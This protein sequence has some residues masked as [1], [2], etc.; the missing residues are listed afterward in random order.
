[1][2][3]G[4]YQG[5]ISGDAKGLNNGL[6]RGLTHGLNRNQNRI[7]AYQEHLQRNGDQDDPLDIDYVFLISIAESRGYALPSTNCQRSGSR[8]IKALKK[9]KIWY[10]VDVLY[11][12]ATD[13]D[14][15]FA[16]LNWKYPQSRQN[17]RVGTLTFT[18]NQG[19]AGNGTNSYLDLNFN[20]SSQSDW[21]AQNQNCWVVGINSN[22]AAASMA[23]F[24]AR[25]TAGTLSVS[26]FYSRIA[27]DLTSARVNSAIADAI[28][29]ANA[30]SI[31][32]YIGYRTA[33]ADMQLD[34]DG[35]FLGQDATATSRAFA[36]RN[37]YLGC[38]NV[39]GVASNFS[40]RQMTHWGFG[41]FTSYRTEW[42]LAWKE[43]FQSL[44]VAQTLPKSTVY[45]NLH[46]NRHVQPI[47][48]GSKDSTAKDYTQVSFGCMV[49]HG[50][51]WFVYYLGSSALIDS[52]RDRVFGAVKKKDN[53]VHLGWDKILDGSSKP[54]V[55]IDIGGIGAFDETQVF[56]TSAIVINGRIFLYYIGHNGS[57][58][59]KVGLA[60]SLGGVIFTRYST[61][62]IFE[63]ATL[64]ATGITKFSVTWNPDTKKY[65]A[66]YTGV[67]QADNMCV[68][69]SVDGINWTKTKNGLIP[70]LGLARIACLKYIRGVYYLW[71]DFSY[72]L[73]SGISEY[74]KLIATTDFVTFIDY[75][76]QEEYLGCN[77]YA[78]GVFCDFFRKPSGEWVMLT[79]SYK[80]QIGK[81]ANEGEEFTCVRIAEL[82]SVTNIP[83]AS[84]ASREVY[85]TY[86]SRH[87][88][89]A[90]KH[91]NGTNFI[92][93]VVGDL[94][95]ISSGS[96]SWT[97]FPTF[98]ARSL[99]YLNGSGAQSFNFPNNGALFNPAN[100]GVKLRIISTDITGTRQLF[101]IGGDIV[102]TL[103][104]GNLQV[105]LSADGVAETKKYITTIDISKPAS[106]NY[107]DDHIYVGFTWIGGVLTLYN[108]FVAFTVGQTTKTNDGALTNVNMSTSDV[109][110]ME[111]T[112]TQ[113]RSATIL[114]NCTDQEWIDLEIG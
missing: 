6:K 20:I 69:E 39:A 100:F 35:D 110:F 36:N 10:G 2:V 103:E 72:R 7:R 50:N 89:L 21:G 108:D 83:I 87:Y 67:A 82:G 41:G 62:A 53:Q 109:V 86:V 13:G 46:W 29:V 16:T 9:Y 57:G 15:D 14:Q 104:A 25:D 42:N 93:R 17:T 70:A 81:T 23:D 107:I 19:Y 8:L 44:G 111:N 113:M 91:F 56:P 97:V 38:E 92:E 76:I 47:I 106:M 77:E 71:A 58:T 4:Q 26:S 55:L 52:D 73:Y 63:D 68:A 60:T 48:N 98:G 99:D 49:E 30:N 37:V 80:N 94:G 96:A 11:V 3:K 43:Y 59:Y 40:T 45:N 12:Y 90:P 78:V 5:L 24:G 27:G 32:D 105:V 95:T 22:P 84:K 112:V 18:A 34:K 102:V 65:V 79:N 75:G 74:R 33:S 114:S 66:V 1:M 54:L 64:G 31:G 28:Q 51:S 85:P 101:K 88:S 61:S